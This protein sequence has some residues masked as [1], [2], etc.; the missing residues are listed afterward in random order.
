MAD[1]RKFFRPRRLDF[2]RRRLPR[3]RLIVALALLAALTPAQAQDLGLKN[4]EAS[5]EAGKYDAA[6]RQ[7]SATV[8]DKNSTKGQAAK[9]LYLRGIAYRRLGKPGQ[10]IA[11]LGAALWLGLPTS[12][13]VRALVNKGLAYRAAGLSSQADTTFSQARSASNSSTVQKLIAED[14]GAA[15]ASAGSSSSSGGSSD[16]GSVWSRLVPSFGGGTSSPPPA[17]PE[18]EPAPQTQTAAAA[19]S[20]GWDASVSDEASE[21]SGNRVSRW[22]GSFG[23]DSA[24]APPAAAPSPAPRTTTPPKTAAPP[25]SAASW[26]ANTQTTRVV[27]EGADSGGS[28]AIGRWFSRNTNSTESAPAPTAAGGDYSVQLAN[29]RSEAEA[30][31]LWKQVAG[32]NSRLASVSPQIEKVQIGS[33]GTFYSLRIGPF[34]DRSESTKVCNSLKRNGTDCTVVSPDGP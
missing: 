12:D 1:H 31:A 7:L 16:S 17:A 22:F 4:G 18:P 29:S 24:P 21:P 20:S 27:S 23:G 2:G 5:L 3:G 14:G 9:A 6:V 8:N 30:Q 15:V 10:A 34:S 28:T 26:S 33:F 25:P 32:A 13:K 11:D 19:P